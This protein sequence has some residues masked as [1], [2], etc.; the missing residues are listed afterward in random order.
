[1]KL[2]LT[3]RQAADELAVLLQIG[4]QHDVGMLATLLVGEARPWRY[5]SE[6]AAEFD[7]LILAEGLV[8]EQDELIAVPGRENFAEGGIVE[9]SGEVDP[10]NHRAERGGE[11]AN[12]DIDRESTRL[13]SSH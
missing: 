3:F 5:R 10:T 1:M 6:A 2:D 8:A 7:L 12:V 13:N 9:R 4:H 11:R